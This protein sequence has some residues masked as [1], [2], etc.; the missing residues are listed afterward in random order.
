MSR[1]LGIDSGYTGIRRVIVE[2]LNTLKGVPCLDLGHEA[3][4]CIEKS[5]L[6]LDDLDRH[7]LGALDRLSML[8]AEEIQ[9][10]GTLLC[11]PSSSQASPVWVPFSAADCDSLLNAMPYVRNPELLARL[12]HLAWLRRDCYPSSLRAVLLYLE[13]ASDLLQHDK[14]SA[15]ADNISLAGRIAVALGKNR[16]A[17]FRVAG[18]IR[19]VLDRIIDS[20]VVM[21][22]LKS[23][24]DVSPDTD[25]Q[26]GYGRAVL[27]AGRCSKTGDEMLAH[28]FFVVASDAAKR[29][30]DRHRVDLC[31]TLAAECYARFALKLGSQ[32]PGPLIA[33]HWLRK[34]IQE[35]ARFQGTRERRERLGRTLARLERE[36]IAAMPSY[37][38]SVV[39][40]GQEAA[41]VDALS[42]SVAGK[43]LDESVAII[44][45]CSN[46]L[47]AK[48]ARPPG[49]Q[50]S[51]MDLI[52][53]TIVD[54]DGKQV[55]EY[56]PARGDSK[57]PGLDDAQL[58][59]A[60]T[61]SFV[62]M[63]R[64]QVASEHI[65]DR[66][67]LRFV[68]AGNGLTPPGHEE[69]ILAGLTAGFNEDW[70]TAGHLLVPQTEMLV[71]H[72]LQAGGMYT[73]KQDQNGR[74][75]EMTLD[76]LVASPEAKDMFDPTLLLDLQYLLC[77][78]PI[79]TGWRNLEAHGL[80]R[81][82]AYSTPAIEYL[83]WLILK[84]LVS[85]LRR[86]TSSGELEGNAR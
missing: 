19:T 70:V 36:A 14:T 84:L 12:R 21:D 71:R 22:L 54:S 20:H 68:V 69:A 29:S 25:M 10:L 40:R 83:W 13:S 42:L 37:S 59:W 49:Q 65:V 76:E 56:V 44:A 18:T 24:L 80:A 47:Q 3:L 9:A 60:V 45:Q 2:H 4:S 5:G 77:T 82:D 64:R 38:T 8:D 52:T 58:H 66:E 32:R 23:L 17:R 67:S 81:D 46:W 26:F 34:C 50:V 75:T 62:E 16:V 57:T 72:L 41:A 1:S 39:L 27:E 86:V 43:P 79:G 11:V 55:A 74:E 48:C 6:E 30:H 85:F 78:N 7:F 35:L 61:V 53:H 51:F 63:L 33:S 31:R 28:D 15:A 73:R